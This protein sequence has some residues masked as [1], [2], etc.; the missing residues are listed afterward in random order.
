VGGDRVP[1]DADNAG[2]RECEEVFGCERI[3]D[4]LDR[5]NAGGDRAGQ[6]RQH[7]RDPGATLGALGSQQERRA[8]RDR[9]ERVPGVVD[10]I[11][12]QRDAVTGD[13]DRA[14]RAI[15]VTDTATTPNPSRERIIEGATRP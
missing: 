3:D 12:R 15:A 13:V 6:D 9:G 2:E 11:G 1:D 5:K 14:L 4:A 7:D 8:E 10:Q